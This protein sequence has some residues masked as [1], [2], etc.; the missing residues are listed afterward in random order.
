MTTVEISLLPAAAIAA[1]AGA[2]SREAKITEASKHLVFFRAGFDRG[3]VILQG[4]DVHGGLDGREIDEDLAVQLRSNL[5]RLVDE[6]MLKSGLIS[7]C[8]LGVI[9]IFSHSEGSHVGQG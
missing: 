4:I 6:G 2:G 5:K 8:P 1:V 7:M 9:R 3:M